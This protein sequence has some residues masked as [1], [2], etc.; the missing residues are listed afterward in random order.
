M[1]PTLEDALNRLFAAGGGVTVPAPGQQVGPTPTPG[2]AGPTPT[3]G[4]PGVPGS[5]PQLAAEAQD[6]YTRAQEALRAGDFARYGDEQRAL[7][8][9][10]NRLV[11]AAR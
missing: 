9:A 6:H 4:A 5:V 7:E 10:I 3:A 11:Q 1:E 2:A 8:D